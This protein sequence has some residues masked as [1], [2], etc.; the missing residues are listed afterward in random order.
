[1]FQ[2]F[3]LTRLRT[4][5]QDASEVKRRAITGAAWTIAGYGTSQIIR[6][7][8]NL[9]LTRLL[10]PEL[11][12]LMALANVFLVGLRLFSDI[13]I[14]PS[15]IQNRR[16]DQNFINTAWTIQVIRSFILCFICLFITWPISHF[17]DEP[18]LLWLIPILS[19]TVIF[20][21]F[22]STAQFTL[23]KELS[24]RKLMI[25]QT[26][27]QII[28]IVIMIV[29]AYFSPTI[30]ALISGGLLGSLVKMIWSHFLDPTVKNRLT[31]DR[32]AASN[33]FKFGRWIFV[34]TA[35]TFLA[36][37]VDRLMLAKF[38]TLELLGIYT[39]AYTLSDIPRQVLS[40]L[41]VSVIFPATAKFAALPRP[42]FRDKLLKNSRLILLPLTIFIALVTSFGDVIITFLYPETFAPA[43]WMLPLLALGLWPSVLVNTTSP[44]LLA[45]GKPRYSAFAY[46]SKVVF[47]I[48]AIYV[49]YL[50]LGELGAILAVVLNDVPYY[51]AFSYGL[52]KEGL[53]DLLTD[54][55]ATMALMGLI[56]LC[57]LLRFLLGWGSPIDALL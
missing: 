51:A 30:W 20:D 7:I 39:I 40:K 4:Y 21:G 12:G 36:N 49:G 32:D 5:W 55:K 15:I 6:F 46:F 57:L 37:Q 29:W 9:I 11:F 31:F 22:T 16:D 42:E 18:R 50:L 25:F 41:N 24:L 56:G 26:V 35:M 34:S 10:V 47:I 38:F 44:A 52:W 3:D 28:Q 54:L 43:A 17:Y 14:G 8:S 2:K 13:G 33:L 19:L 45:L 23:S 53:L 48:V 1:M 27:S